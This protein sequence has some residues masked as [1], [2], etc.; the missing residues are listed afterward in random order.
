[1]QD[2]PNV[3]VDL[4]LDL[5]FRRQNEAERRGYL[6]MDADERVFGIRSKD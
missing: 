4:I 5:A 1:M 3:V 2:L 6:L